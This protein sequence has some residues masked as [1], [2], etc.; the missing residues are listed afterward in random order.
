MRPADRERRVFRTWR[1][2]GEVGRGG[3]STTGGKPTEGTRVEGREGIRGRGHKDAE[4]KPS[5]ANVCGENY[6]E[7]KKTKVPSSTLSLPELLKGIQSR[8]SCQSHTGSE[9]KRIG[10]T[11][12]KQVKSAGKKRIRTSFKTAVNGEFTTYDHYPE[13]SHSPG[14]ADTLKGKSERD[15]IPCRAWRAQERVSGCLC[16]CLW[17]ILEA[18]GKDQEGT[19][20]TGKNTQLSWLRGRP[21]RV[22]KSNDRS[23]S[24]EKK[25]QPVNRIDVKSRS[26]VAAKAMTSNAKGG[27]RRRARSAQCLAK[28]RLQRGENGE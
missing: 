26:D 23:R 1:W 20:R 4:I 2:G 27:F 11:V 8:G 14:S 21:V 15:I 12:G 13:G 17:I 25:E 10:G 3:R 5:S 24:T 16:R 6:Q 28:R 9:K 22:G 18:R 7:K 19:C